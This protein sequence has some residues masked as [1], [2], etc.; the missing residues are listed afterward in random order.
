MPEPVHHV[1]L[2]LQVAAKR[3]GEQRD[4]LA[5]LETSDQK[6]ETSCCQDHCSSWGWH[7]EVL[8]EGCVQVKAADGLQVC[9]LARLAALDRLYYR[10]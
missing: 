4:E 6:W 5:R 3:G 10:V 7:R 2:F 1:A 8:K 9:S